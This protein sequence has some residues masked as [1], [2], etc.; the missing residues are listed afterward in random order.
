MSGHRGLEA[1]TPAGPADEAGAGGATPAS[2]PPHPSTVDSGIDTGT[3]DFDQENNAAFPLEAQDDTSEASTDEGRHGR[4]LEQV[5]ILEGG[6]E[7]YMLR[8]YTQVLGGRAEDLQIILALARR[9][10]RDPG[11]HTYVLFHVTWA[12]KPE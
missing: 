2:A 11:V 5:M 7:A 6:F 4:L 10:I 9:E 3:R 1:Q 8:G 12:R